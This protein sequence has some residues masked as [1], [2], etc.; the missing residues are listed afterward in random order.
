LKTNSLD[1]LGKDLLKA[2][3]KKVR[4]LER[5]PLS[6]GKYDPIK[7]KIFNKILDMERESK[8]TLKLLERGYGKMSKL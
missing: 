6:M 2:Y 1:E 7:E 4:R 8:E 3:E 5:I